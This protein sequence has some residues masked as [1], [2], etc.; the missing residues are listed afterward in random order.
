MSDGADTNEDDEQV[1]AEAETAHSD[2]TQ[3][4]SETDSD[5]VE[6][7]EDPS[8]GED[9]EQQDSDEGSNADDAESADAEDGED[10]EPEEG[11]PKPADPATPPPPD[12]YTSWDEVRREAAEARRLRAE[13]EQ[14]TPLL[15]RV[16]EQRQQIQQP[17]TPLKKPTWSPPHADE[18]EVRRALDVL[19]VDQEAFKKLPEATREKA[20]RAHGFIRDR[21]D[22]YTM[23]PERLYEDIVVPK[24]EGSVYAF[25]MVDLEKRI[26]RFEED[27]LRQRGREELSRHSTVI[28]TPADEKEVVDFVTAHKVPIAVAVEHVAMK[29]KLAAL[30]AQKIKVDERSKSQA[31]LSNRTREAQGTKRGQRPGKPTAELLGTTDAREIAKRLRAKGQLE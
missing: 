4:S 21:W 24:L 25:K 20:L 22:E 28:K 11:A 14:M 18:P 9:G 23:N 7:T 5:S 12:G 15:M 10:E 26:A 13:R 8:A 30:E 29:R 31:A 16:L 27:A 6:P 17:E 1:S 19:R 3:E 2:A